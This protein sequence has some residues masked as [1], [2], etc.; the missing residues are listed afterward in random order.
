MDSMHKIYSVSQAQQQRKQVGGSTN[1]LNDRIADVN[2]RVEVCQMLSS[3]PGPYYL[4]KY[5]DPSYQ[6][7]VPEEKVACSGKMLGPLTLNY[8]PV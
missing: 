8:E 6:R 7:K 2:Q 5:N 1:V 3:N 4:N